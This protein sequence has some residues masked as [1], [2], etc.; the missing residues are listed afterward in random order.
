MNLGGAGDL[1]LSGLWR[2]DSALVYSLIARNQSLTGAQATILANAGYPDVPASSNN[3]VFYSG[4]GAESFKGYGV[5]DLSVTYNVPLVHSLRPWVKLELFNALNNEKQIAWNTTI[6]QNKTTVDN[7][8]LGSTYTQGASFGTATGNTVTN[9]FNSTINAFP[10]A[11]NGA[12][13]GG[14]TFRMAVGLR[15]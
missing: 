13:P 4:R 15:F 2:V 6:S 11:Y 12:Q 9:L 8:G 3:E 5:V 14:R 10:V 7:L 1:S